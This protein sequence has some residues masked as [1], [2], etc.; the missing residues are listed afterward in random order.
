[1]SKLP[2]NPG[3]NADDQEKAHTPDKLRNDN[4]R[5]K[6]RDMPEQDHTATPGDY[7]KPPKP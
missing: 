3:A 1:M 7:E 5:W 6:D 4:A 2:L